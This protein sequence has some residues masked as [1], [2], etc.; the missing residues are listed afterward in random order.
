MARALNAFETFTCDRCRA[1][2]SVSATLKSRLIVSSRWP[3]GWAH[4][5]GHDYCPSCV[6]KIKEVLALV[7]PNNAVVLPPGQRVWIA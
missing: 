5:D 2:D 3:Q 6:T 1:R 7:N 4:F